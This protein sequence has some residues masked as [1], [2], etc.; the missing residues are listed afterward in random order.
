MA[1]Y[2]KP[3]HADCHRLSLYCLSRLFSHQFLMKS[4]VT[5]RGTGNT[6]W[7]SRPQEQIRFSVTHKA[8][9]GLP[10]YSPSTKRSCRLGF[11]LTTQSVSTLM[12]MAYKADERQTEAY[13]QRPWFMKN[14]TGK[15][16]SRNQGQIFILLG[17]AA[18]VGSR[19][20]HPQQM[21]S[22][23]LL[24]TRPPGLSAAR[25]WE[26][27]WCP[28]HCLRWKTTRNR[29]AQAPESRKPPQGE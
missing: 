29:D 10:S 17:L 11:S 15:R 3:I 28:V 27:G 25:G 4:Q 13:A 21:E 2:H 24:R 16:L 19:E 18:E 26:T 22:R 23:T 20:R 5:S 7:G 8:I 9:G 14:I 12:H 6:Q 1:D